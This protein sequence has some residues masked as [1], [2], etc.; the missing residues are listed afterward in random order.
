MST[1]QDLVIRPVTGNSLSEVTALGKVFKMSGYFKDIRD[2]AQAVVK[3]LYGRELGFT[4]IVSVMGIHIIEGKPSLSSNLMAA[5]IKRSGRYDYRVKEH[6]NTRC[7]IEFR[8]GAE[9]LGE[10]DFTIEDAKMAGVMRQG[11]GW[12]KYPKAML[13]ARA[14]SAGMRTYCPDVGMC[15]LYVPEE[16]GA[17]VTEEG[18]VTEMPKSARP[19]EVTTEDIPLGSPSLGSPALSGG[20]PLVKGEPKT[21]TPSAQPPLKATVSEFDGPASDAHLLPYYDQVKEEVK[22]KQEK[23]P[24]DPNFV[25]FE[26]CVTVAQRKAFARA[27]KSEFPPDTPSKDVELLRKDWLK[28]RGFCDPLSGEPTS[29]IIPAALFTD[30]LNKAR[31]FAKTLNQKLP[32]DGSGIPF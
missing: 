29:A 9:I 22:A 21:T 4:P 2:E 27:W 14:L 20:A 5:L 26:G 13:F 10:S 25:E 7:L 30:Y 8:E 23:K 31:H 24:V 6:T 32:S 3:I 15:P 11:G 16:L 28:Q 17:S 18:E 12:S 1:V 19:V